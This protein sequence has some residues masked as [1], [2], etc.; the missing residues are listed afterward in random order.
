MYSEPIQ[1]CWVGLK[2]KREWPKEAGIFT[3]LCIFANQRKSP[4]G[5]QR[6]SCGRAETLR[7]PLVAPREG[8]QGSQLRE[9][10][11]LHC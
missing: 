7:C 2:C 6:S 8:A 9:L 10:C 4:L 11:P 3:R 1:T 5:Q